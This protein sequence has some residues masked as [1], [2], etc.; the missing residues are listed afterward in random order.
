MFHLQDFLLS[1]FRAKLGLGL[2]SGKYSKPPAEASKSKQIGDEL[3]PGISPHMFKSLIGKGHALFSTKRQQ[4]AQEF[5]L[6]LI[7][8]LEV[9]SSGTCFNL[10][11]FVPQKGIIFTCTIIMLTL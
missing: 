9:L 7:N 3:Q 6:H 4:D 8:T 2:L 5:F 11:M 1:T 10:L